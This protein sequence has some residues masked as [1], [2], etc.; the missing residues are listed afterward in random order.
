M[1]TPRVILQQ[2]HDLGARIEYREG[3][4][5]LRAGRRPVPELLVEQARAAKDGLLSL[6]SAENAPNT[7]TALT[8]TLDGTFGR[9]RPKM[10]RWPGRDYRSRAVP[11]RPSQLPGPIEPPL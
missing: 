1:S 10:R 4:L 3:R 9:K 11:S 2:L 8:T 5:A 6:L 7:P